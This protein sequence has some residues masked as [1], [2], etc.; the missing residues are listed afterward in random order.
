MEWAKILHADTNLEKLN[1]K[2]YW[3]GMFKNGPYLLD[4]GTLKSSV[5]HK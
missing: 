5:S 1:V 3:V 4:H 2:S